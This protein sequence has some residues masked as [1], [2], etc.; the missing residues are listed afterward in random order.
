MYYVRKIRWE[1]DKETRAL[2]DGQSKI[3]TW[4]YNKLLERANQL[5]KTYRETQD[6]QI[7]VTLYSERGLR[8]LIPEMK[9]E[10]PFLTEVYSSPLKNA[11]LRLSRAIRDFQASWHGKRKGQRIRWPKFHRW[12]SNWFSLVYDE[13]WKGYRLDGRILSIHLGKRSGKRYIVCGKLVEP[14]PLRKDERVMRLRIV[15]HAGQFFAIFAMEREAPIPHNGAS[16]RVIAL[17]PNHK[18]LAYGV[19]TDGRAIEIENL[20]SLR[21]LDERIDLLKRR[22]DRCR[23]RARV[24]AQDGEESVMRRHGKT[25]RR[26][27]YLNHRLQQAYQRRR[28]E[29]KTYIFAIANRLCQQYDVIAIGD[30]VP[31]QGRGI[32]TEMKR[33]M[34]NR[35]LIGRLRDIVGWV[36]LRS[37]K[38]FIRY[39]EQG[40]TR[41]CHSCRFVIE[42]GLDPRVREWDCPKCGI[43]HQR[44]ENAAMNGLACVLGKL[45]MPR[46]GHMPVTV[47]ARWIWR[48]TPRGVQALP[49]GATVQSR[50]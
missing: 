3:V 2:L 45:G 30:Y 6:S 27:E 50:S 16:L 11:A 42:A 32:T 34:Y 39:D 1:V 37:G 38:K 24:D 10:Y 25:S 43:H 9:R 19:G 23:R 15:K 49:G 44:D 40:T 13:A 8:D 46:S 22:R 41:T 48:V 47:T 5:R 14:L 29:T 20:R 7:G 28:D 36:A 26:W 31:D 33:A 17:D 35:S 21:W 18:N 12:S 4:L